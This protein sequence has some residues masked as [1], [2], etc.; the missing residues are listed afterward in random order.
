MVRLQLF[1]PNCYVFIH[2]IRIHSWSKTIT[3]SAK[4]LPAYLLLS[5]PFSLFIIFYSLL[6]TDWS[7]FFNIKRTNIPFASIL[8][9]HVSSATALSIASADNLSAVVFRYFVLFCVWVPKDTCREIRLPVPA[10]CARIVSVCSVYCSKKNLHS[11]SSLMA[12]G[13]LSVSNLF[14][15]WAHIHVTCSRSNDKALCSL[16]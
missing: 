5:A 10:S 16:P 8:I 7:A 11:L 2:L 1:L 15:I 4:D 13:Y 9:V 6:P 3:V 14:S 12:S